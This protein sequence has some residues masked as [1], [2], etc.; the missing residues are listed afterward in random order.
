MNLLITGANGFVGKH[1][2]KLLAKKRPDIKLFTPSHD[3]FDLLDSCHLYG[4]LDTFK[5]DHIVHLAARVGGIGANQSKPATFLYDNLLM[6]MNIVHAANSTPGVKKLINIGTICSYPKHTEVPFKE[7]NIWDGYP[8]ETNAPYGIAKRAVM[9]YAIASNFQYGT[10]VV[11]LMAVN[12]A[13]EY[14][15]FHPLT[16]HVIPAIILKIDKAMDDGDSDIKL[17]GTGQATREFL[18]AG[19]CARAI[20]MSL[21]THVGPDPVNIGTGK[22]IT[23][24]VLANAIKSF[25]KYQGNIMFTSQVSDG[26]PRRCLDVSRAKKIFGFKPEVDLSEMIRREV[27]YYYSLKEQNPELID[28]YRAMIS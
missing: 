28:S 22:E 6:G 19:D 20:L 7:E 4:Y 2:V 14:D 12:M 15:N 26:Q 1:L 16:S 23:I 13:G 10:N 17:W 3:T 24:R 5:I 21:E 8:E 11:N 27:Q 18:Y 25:M 9:A